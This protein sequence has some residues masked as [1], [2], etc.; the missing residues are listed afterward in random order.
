VLCGEILKGILTGDGTDRVQVRALALA[1]EQT[2]GSLG[3]GL[4]LDIEG[5]AGNDLI[6]GTGLGDGVLLGKDGSGKGTNGAEDG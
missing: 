3:G 1:Q 5:L 6:A 4:P 2:D